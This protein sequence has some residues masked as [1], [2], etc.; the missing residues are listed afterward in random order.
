M[1]DLEGDKKGEETS[2]PLHA[3]KDGRKDEIAEGDGDPGRVPAMGDEPGVPS[4]TTP[5]DPGDAVGSLSGDNPVSPGPP[6]EGGGTST[7]LEGPEEGGPGAGQQG[8]EGQPPR[9]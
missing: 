6:D 3:Y 5:S 8:T 4:P 9:R 7:P 2:T 1:P